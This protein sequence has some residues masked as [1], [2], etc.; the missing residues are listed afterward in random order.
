MRESFYTALAIAILFLASA[1]AKWV[2]PSHLP[3]YLDQV[4][5]ILEILA[6]ALL[7]IFH[8]R[9]WSW[10]SLTVLFSLWLGYSLFWFIRN[11]NCGCFGEA[12]P[13]SAGITATVD[14]IV[15]GLAFW[16]WGKIEVNA[17]KKMLFIVI[18][19]LVLVVGFLIASTISWS[20]QEQ[21]NSGIGSAQDQ[22][23]PGAS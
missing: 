20:R 15:L 22:V 19:G 21:E 17:K 2:F 16:N 3:L 8:R 1:L 9:A 14:A 5:A 6:A 13:I 23:F 12:L 4:T 18:D 10:A 7:L 11:E